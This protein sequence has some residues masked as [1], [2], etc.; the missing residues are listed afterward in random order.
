VTGG[1]GFVG[2]AVVRALVGR[3]EHVTVLTRDHAKAD[4]A[5]GPQ[6]RAVTSL[7]EIGDRE[8]IDVMLNLAGE[9]LMGGLWT[10]SRL[11][12]F[13]ESR[14]GT[15]ENLVALAARLETRPSLLVNGSAIGYYGISEEAEFTEIDSPGTDIVARLCRDWEAAAVKAEALGLRVVR[16]RM[17][18]V[19]D[20]EGG[21]LQALAFPAR[22][23]L[24][25]KF[26]PGRQWMSWISLPDMVR[27][28]LFA[29]DR[30]DLSGP[31]N[32]A[33]PGAVRQTEFIAALCRQLRRPRLFRI[34]AFLFRLL[35]GGMDMLFADGQRV[36]PARALA[37]GFEFEHP[38]LPEALAA[39]LSPRAAG[40]A[41]ANVYYDSHCSFC[42]AEIGHY[43]RL[44]EK[45][46]APVSF[47][48]VSEVPADTL[49]AYGLPPQEMNRRLYLTTPDGGIISGADAML[50]IWDRFPRYRKFARL[51]RLP[52]FHLFACFLY[53]GLI[54]PYFEA[55]KAGRKA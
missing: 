8:R 44:K 13:F 6:A 30:P 50:A 3:G 24:G 28:I 27:L 48:P 43:C 35:P 54:V 46:G 1:T 20:G 9:P 17:G 41:E 49:A 22:L 16:L 15:A 51:F 21:L 5:F 25:A 33:A 12:R 7:D 36:I 45:E 52:G 32:A 18:L 10:K 42:N 29:A 47:L 2:R 40:L 53:D 55:A 37:A 26:G 14:V 4:Y 31:V 39:L 23:G 11:A 34:P 38:G 19:L